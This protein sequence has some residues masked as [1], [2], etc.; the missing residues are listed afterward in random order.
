M[1]TPLTNTQ[2]LTLIHLIL[3]VVRDVDLDLWDA[4]YSEIFELMQQIIDCQDGSIRGLEWPEA[5]EADPD[6]MM[7]NFVWTVDMDRPQKVGYVPVVLPSPD[8]DLTWDKGL[9]EQCV[10]LFTRPLFS[11]VFPEW[12]KDE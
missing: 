10:S 2:K 3:T 12:Y 1:L 6:S 9:K 7:S 8:Y 4:A 11:K 5:L